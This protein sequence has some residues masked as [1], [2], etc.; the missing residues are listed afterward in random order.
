MSETDSSPALCFVDT[1]IWLYAFISGS[2]ATKSS[3][4]RQLLRD[5]EGS[6]V[7]SSQV[8]NEVCVNLLKK[9]QVPESQIRQLVQSFCQ[10]YP[11]ILLDRPVQLSASQLRERFSF[12][13][14]DSMIVAAAIDCGAISLYSEDMQAGLKINERL[15]IVNPFEFDVKPPD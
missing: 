1:N 2:D 12:S 6:I 10:K 4:A 13:F 9:A 14:W 7:V 3:T 8:I 15:T 5:N 11:V